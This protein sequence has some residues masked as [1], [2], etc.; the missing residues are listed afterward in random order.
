MQRACREFLAGARFAVDQ[1]R[2]RRRRD[3]LDAGADIADDHGITHHAFDA[4]VALVQFAAQDEVLAAQRGALEAALHRVQHLRHREGLEQEVGGTGTQRIDRRFQVGIRR[5][6]HHV[7]G[8]ALIAQLM[9]PLHARTS[10][11]GDVE[12][13]QIEMAAVEKFLGLFHAA[14]NGHPAAAR[15]QRT[16]QEADHAGFIVNHQYR[17]VAP[18][19]ELTCRNGGQGCQRVS[20]IL[21]FCDS[22]HH[23]QFAVAWQIGRACP[24]TNCPTWTDWAGTFCP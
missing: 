18:G 4:I 15:F 19:R 11:Q 7:A 1:H 23:P 24:M 13:D 5:H 2:G 8:E 3:A 17:L 6:Q 9:Q 10:G 14:G 20:S 21:F 12:H 16:L 22:G